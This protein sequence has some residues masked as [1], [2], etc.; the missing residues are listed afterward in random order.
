M[1]VAL[2]HQGSTIDTAALVCVKE[3][4]CDSVDIVYVNGAMMKTTLALA[5]FGMV[6]VTAMTTTAF[7]ASKTNRIEV[8]YVPPKNPAHQEIYTD[9]K[10]HGALEKLQKFL[11]PVRLPETLRISVEECDGEP[12]AFYED[13]EITICYEYIYELKKNMPQEKTPSGIAPIDTVIGPL[14]EV[15]LHEFGHAL[16]D[17][18]ELPVFGREEDAADQLAAY[19]LLQFGESEARRLIAGTAYAYHIDEMKADPCRSTED[20]ANEHGTP[21]QRF[22]NVLCI[23]YGADTKQF[24]DIVSEGYLPETRAEYCEEE[25]EQVQDAFDELVLPHIDLVL[26]E[27]IQGISWLREPEQ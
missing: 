9:L 8:R 7:A 21:A 27:E 23:A 2:C 10:Q 19:I 17:M 25:Y 12:D 16:F 20:Y 26:A 11:S 6:L 4:A 18:L 3:V 13:A 14:F 24:A 22:F 1:K 15:S 5:V